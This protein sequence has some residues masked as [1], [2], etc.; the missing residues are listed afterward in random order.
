VSI[1]SERPADPIHSALPDESLLSSVDPSCTTHAEV[2]PETSI[3]PTFPADYDPDWA[4]KNG[5]IKPKPKV[6]RPKRYK[7]PKDTRVFKVAMGV[8]ALRA[9]GYRLKA[10]AEMM[11]LSESTVKTYVH[12]ANKNGWIDINT[13]ADPD[14]ALEIVLK[15]QAVRN[16]HEVLDEKEVVVNKE[17]GQTTE[18]NRRSN[19]AI[20]MAT[21]VAKGTGLFK[22]HTVDKGTTQ[23]PIAMALK[24]HVEMPQMP[25]HY[26]L[27]EARQGSGGVPNFDAEIIDAE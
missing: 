10:I 12:Q 14:D 4:N 25:S 26:A 3:V 20:S 11:E 22:T 17:T 21:E 24:V 27:P 9:Q 19:R 13:F 15:S 23:A 7:K 2:S 16:I 6:K 8:V 1:T 5:Y 18:L